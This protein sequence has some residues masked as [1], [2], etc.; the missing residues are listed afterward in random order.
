M[1]AKNSNITFGNKHT[2]HAFKDIAF[3]FVG[4]RKVYYIISS[5]IIVLGVIFYVKNDG[6]KLGI[7]FK[8]GRTYIV[9]FD[10]SMETEDV[11]AKLTPFFGDESP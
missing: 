11:K 7:D 5:I 9:H 1:L 10:K 6:L 2:I 3:N 4:H 8:G